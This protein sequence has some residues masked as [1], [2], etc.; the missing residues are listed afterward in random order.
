[1]S[2]TG[3]CF[4]WILFTTF[5]FRSVL[6][7]YCYLN[8]GLLMIGSLE[9]GL[10]VI[11]SLDCY[12]FSIGFFNSILLAIGDFDW[13]FFSVTFCSNCRAFCTF[14]W[15]LFVKVCLDYILSTFCYCYNWG[16]LGIWSFTWRLFTF[17]CLYGILLSIGYFDHGLIL[18]P[19]FDIVSFAALDETSLNDI[20]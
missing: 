15:C 9:R 4:D 17:C 18:S 14:S 7:I 13:N 3:G 2:F 16:L 11:D 20:F 10:F 12:F 19:I 8:Y 6:F 5:L 1:M